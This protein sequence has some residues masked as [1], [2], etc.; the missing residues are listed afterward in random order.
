M[1]GQFDFVSPGAAFADALTQQLAQRKAD[2]RQQ[3]IDTITANAERRSQQEAENMNA[4]RQSEMRI[5]QQQAEDAKVNNITRNMTRGQDLSHL[6]PDT[7]S[8]LQSRG[9]VMQP[10]TPLA[11]APITAAGQGQMSAPQ[12]PPPQY[13]G[14]AE[15]QM[16]S[17]EGDKDNALISRL[18]SSGNPDD[19]MKADYLAS[20]QDAYGRV[21]PEI[22]AQVLAPAKPFMYFDVPHHKIVNTGTSIPFNAD[23]ATIGY[24][25][26]SY[27]DERPHVIGFT[28][29]NFPVTMDKLGRQTVNGK[30]YSG[31]V[32]TASEKN[33]EL[34]GAKPINIKFGSKQLTDHAAAIG[35]LDKTPTPQNAKTAQQ[36]AI[37]LIASSNAPEKVKSLARLWV[38]D[39]A[40]A[41]QVQSG[42]HEGDWTQDEKDAFTNLREQSWP[43]DAAKAFKNANTPQPSPFDNFF[44]HLIQVPQTDQ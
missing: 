27:T 40:K 34:R 7:L 14:S 16:A 26:S 31:T 13:I 37:D 38:T 9:M 24:P 43:S 20:N 10:Q 8:Q 15:E 30:P 23:V 11:S 22:K 32:F 12:A 29:D 36:S 5:A 35:L 25:P 6:D 1:A 2:Q 4:Y 17:R 39:P 3:L 21:A 18:I 33:A 44:T 42:L 41:L 19:K 28:Q